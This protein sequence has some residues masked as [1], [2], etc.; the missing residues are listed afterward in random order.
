MNVCF[1]Y[2]SRAEITTAIRSTVAD[3]SKPLSSSSAKRPFS[4]SSITRNIRSRKL[5][6]VEEESF[7]RSRTP[8]VTN[9]L[10]GTERNL[11]ISRQGSKMSLN[12]FSSTTDSAFS[13]ST[14]SNRISPDTSPSP[15]P[16]LKNNVAAIYPE[17]ELIDATILD[18]H[19]YTAGSPPLDLLVRT[20]GVERLS[21]FMLWQCHEHTSIVFTKCLWPELDLWNFLP[22]LVEW[23][24]WRRKD[25]PIPETDAYKRA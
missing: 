18:R 10:P 19:M 9:H 25:E 4:E 22:I 2:T 23:Q 1:P 3:Y 17:A 7:E 24:W 11:E 14:T 5:A 12:E 6:P 21:D 8:S 13:S 20:S 16:S 15:P